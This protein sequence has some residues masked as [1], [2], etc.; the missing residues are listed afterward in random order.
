MGIERRIRRVSERSS[1]RLLTRNLTLSLGHTPTP[2]TVRAHQLRRTYINLPIAHARSPKPINHDINLE[3]VELFDKSI[4]MADETRFKPIEDNIT[5]LKTEVSGLKTDITSDKEDV[6]SLSNDV[7]NINEKMDAL[8][9]AMNRL[10]PGTATATTPAHPDQQNDARQQHTT[11][12]TDQDAPQRGQASHGGYAPTL[13]AQNLGGHHTEAST[14]QTLQYRPQYHTN[15]QAPLSWPQPPHH[16]H[17]QAQNPAQVFI[18][19]ELEKDR[20]LYPEAGKTLSSIESNHS[21]LMTKPYMFLYR[22]GLSTM[23]QKLDARPT[24]TA[25]EYTDAMLTL[26]SDR[27]AFDP[28]DFHDIF[29]HLRKVTRD[30]LERPWAAVRRWTQY[31]WDS[32]EDGAITW[33][34]ADVIQEEKVRICLTSTQNH[35]QQSNAN[36]YKIPARRNQG[37][38]E[39]AC[40]AYNTRNG[41]HH[42]DSH[43]EGGIYCLHIC[44]YCDSV[45]KT[46]FHSVRECERRVTH[47]RNDNSHQ[48]SRNRPQNHSNT[49]Q[50]PHSYNHNQMNFQASKNG[51]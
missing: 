9:N 21:R 51:Y 39:V 35:H 32:I 24:M 40:R 18:Q 34:D 45:G 4:A 15:Q 2:E 25:S 14:Q 22:E 46:C 1:I 3:R 29:H 13:P 12:H 7:G 37:L 42:R 6:S 11:Y 33:A 28:K 30:S 48:I 10:D 8:I 44:T 17:T 47:A 26:L 50:P 43:P 36:T 5:A 41:C 16:S 20:F 49:F 31:I 23:K 38:Q 27:R 19:R